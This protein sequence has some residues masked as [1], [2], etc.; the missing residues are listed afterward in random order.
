MI[1]IVVL[2]YNEAV[3]LPGLLE[4][5][6]AVLSKQ[7]EPFRILVVDDGSK[8]GTGDAARRS[9]EGLPVVVLRHAVNQGV[10]KAFDTGVRRAAGDAADADIIITMEGDGTNDP[11]CLPAML[12]KFRQ[13]FDVVCASRYAPGGA[14]RGF[15]LKR[16]VLSRGA[17]A[18]ARL[19]FRVP[20]IRDY[21]LFYKGYRA[22][23][24]KQALGRF[25]DRFIEGRGFA[26]NAEILVKT[27]RN[28]ALRCA[29]V[30][31]IYRYDLKSGKS[32]MAIVKNL[33]EYLK[34][35]K[36]GK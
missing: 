5:L 14:Y 29:E 16:Y 7:S 3:A 33:V 8:D 15:P 10:A 12:D 2:A 36:A 9:A 32:K 13:G 1:H 21:T 26:A 6:N 11:D 30:P 35:F 24:L 34:L 19:F 20:G 17:N 23:L 28:R 22:R 18:L 31:M 27:C 4:K 25:G